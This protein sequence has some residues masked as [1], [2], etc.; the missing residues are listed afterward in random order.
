MNKTLQAKE[1]LNKHIL[2]QRKLKQLRLPSE[3]ALAEQLGYS[4]ATIGKALGVL[5]GEGVILRKRGAGAFI[6]D[7][8]KTHTMTI[9]IALRNAY[10]FSDLHFRMIVEEIT[11]KAKENNVQV[12]IYDHLSISFKNDP[13]KN[14]LIQDIRSGD[15]D[16]VL[17][18]S[19]MPISIISKIREICPAVLINNIFGDGNEV[20]CVSCDYFQVGFLAGKYLLENGHRKIAY[21]TEDTSHPESTFDFSGLK[22]AC[23][24]AGVEISKDD[25]LDTLQD[26]NTFRERVVNFF[27][28]S[29]YTACFVRRTKYAARMIPILQNN[30]IKVPENLSIIASGTCSY[31]VNGIKLSIIDNQLDKM[32][33]T[34]LDILYNLINNDKTEGG[35]ALLEPK[36]LKHDS[37]RNVHN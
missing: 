11:K 31:P 1:I 14:S 8:K 22:A 28:D 12:K 19:R 32:C 30:G 4:R 25:I 20:P 18:A 7:S 15:I 21:V 24:M 5:E 29:D 33:H 10:N 35:I 27:K 17:I 23:T 34:G 13:D 3:R 2:R 36:L 9:A 37:C 6:V 16:G 26:L